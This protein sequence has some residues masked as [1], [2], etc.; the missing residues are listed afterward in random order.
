MMIT[1]R[2]SITAVALAIACAS[3]PLF[4]SGAFAQDARE[5]EMIGMHQLCDHGDRKACIK[6]GMMIQQNHDHME[7]WRRTHPE[8][9]W[10]ER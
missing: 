6:F 4:T 2:Q 7:A 3:S 1:F 8:W 9:F 5:A 10:W